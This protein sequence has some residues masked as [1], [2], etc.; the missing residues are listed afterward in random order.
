MSQTDFLDALK[1]AIQSLSKR[2]SEFSEQASRCEAIYKD[3]AQLKLFSSK[4]K[5]NE[6]IRKTEASCANLIDSFSKDILEFSSSLIEIWKAQSDDIGINNENIE[7]IIQV[8]YFY[9][10]HQCFI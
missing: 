10:N 5:T 9:S 3:L 1:Q 4:V 8:K 7:Y 6:Y 2:T